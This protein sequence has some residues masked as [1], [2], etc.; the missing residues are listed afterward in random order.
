MGNS[1]YAGGVWVDACRTRVPIG[2]L[3]VVR[4]MSCPVAGDKGGGW[5]LFVALVIGY[6][7]TIAAVTTWRAERYGASGMTAGMASM[8]AAMGTGLSSAT[9][10]GMPLA[11]RL[12]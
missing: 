9:P 8:M 7:L 2:T 5:I 6:A 4:I 10:L 12:G 3:W 11:P 1:S